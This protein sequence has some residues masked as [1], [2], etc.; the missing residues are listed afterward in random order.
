[1]EN[2]ATFPPRCFWFRIWRLSPSTAFLWQLNS[3]VIVKGTRPG[4]T[5]SGGIEQIWKKM[6][7]RWRW[8]SRY[9][10][11][12]SSPEARRA[13][14]R[15]QNRRTCGPLALP[16]IYPCWRL[17]RVQRNDTEQQEQCCWWELSFE[18]NLQWTVSLWVLWKKAVFRGIGSAIQGD[19]C[20]LLWAALALKKI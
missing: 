4:M 8:G 7:Q 15:P 12:L 16:R 5:L 20:T 6:G 9:R 3:P 13:E 10:W 1:M 18:E 11:P 2:G 14:R 19:Q 17:E